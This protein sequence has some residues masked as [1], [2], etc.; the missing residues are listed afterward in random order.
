MIRALSAAAMALAWVGLLAGCATSDQVI[1]SARGDASYL[2][3]DQVPLEVT[4]AS[5]NNRYL[6]ICLKATNPDGWSHA[7][8][9]KSTANGD[10]LDQLEMPAAALMPVIQ[11]ERLYSGCHHEATPVAV[12][13]VARD[14]D[15]K[16][17]PGQPDA[18]YVVN[19]AGQ[20]GLRY[21]S[22]RFTNSRYDRYAIDLSGSAI[23]R[24]YVNG[25]PYM[26]L[27]VPV[28]TAVDAAAVMTMGMVAIACGDALCDGAI[29]GALEP[30][31]GEN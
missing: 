14:S 26:W 5:R 16:L 18:V 12:M 10:G 4:A 2:A 9:I 21:L 27:L 1:A 23:Y 15:I 20:W 11:V 28:A 3:V 8:T 19:G 24:Q 30:L 25:R 7:Y 17:R 29:D 13:M 6:Y 22:A 31:A